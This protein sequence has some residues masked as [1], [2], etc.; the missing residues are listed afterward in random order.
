MGYTVVDPASVIA[1]HLSEIIKA[2]AAELLSRQDTRNLIDNV[3]KTA[4]AVVELIPAQMSVGEVQRCCRT[5]SESAFPSVTSSRSW[6]LWATQPEPT[7][8][9]MSSQN[10]CGLEWGAPYAASTGPDGIAVTT[11]EPS[12]EQILVDSLDAT[13]HGAF[14]APSRRVSGSD[15]AWQLRANAWLQP[16]S[17]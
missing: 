9:S 8:I 15:Q 1:T 10:T 4:P 5:W 7:R 11:L 6:R 2:N 12:L 3:K 13:E 17:S 16:G 14:L